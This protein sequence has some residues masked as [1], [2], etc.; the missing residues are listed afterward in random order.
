MDDPSP[1]VPPDP[2]LYPSLYPVYKDGVVVGYWDPNDL[3]LYGIDL[4][5]VSPDVFGYVPFY[6]DGKLLGYMD[7]NQNW[8]GGFLNPQN[9]MVPYSLMSSPMLSR[10]DFDLSSVDNPLEITGWQTPDGKVYT[11][12]GELWTLPFGRQLEVSNGEVVASLEIAP[13][14]KVVGFTD[15]GFALLESNGQYC[16]VPYT[17]TGRN[18]EGDSTYYALVLDIPINLTPAGDGLGYFYPEVPNAYTP[19]PSTGNTGSGNTGS[20]D[21]G[22]GDTGSGDT[23]GGDTGGGNTG[24]GNTGGGNTG[25]GD[26]GGG[27]TGGGDTGG[28]NTGGGNTGGGI[29]GGNT[30]DGD[31]DGVDIGQGDDWFP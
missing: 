9:P 27:D 16:K 28:G 25:G 2:T 5:P 4:L 12:T 1:L 20:G 23:G 14:I 18:T 15:D 8:R 22:G 17:E 24:G 21:T 11:K 6:S 19:F 26:T 13:G 7:V 31:N 29:G 3:S 10:S 30:E